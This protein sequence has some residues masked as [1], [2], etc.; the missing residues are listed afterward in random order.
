MSGKWLKIESGVWL[1]MSRV[2]RVF[3]EGSTPTPSEKWYVV[4]DLLKTTEIIVGGL[5]NEGTARHAADS[6]MKAVTWQKYIVAKE[7]I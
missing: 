4:A 7:E 1:N 2:A 3:V 6:I 5:K